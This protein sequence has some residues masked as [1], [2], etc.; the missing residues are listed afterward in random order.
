MTTETGKVSDGFHTFDELYEHRSALFLGLMKMRP[1]LSWYADKHEDG[2]MF[3]DMFIVGMTLP[4]GQVTYHLNI[5][6]WRE[7]V[8]KTHA[9]YKERAPHWDGHSSEDVVERLLDWIGT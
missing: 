3:D 8:R 9:C 6:P 4:A 7:A 1:G 2:S 5:D